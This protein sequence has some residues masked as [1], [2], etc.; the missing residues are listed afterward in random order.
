MRKRRVLGVVGVGV[1]GSKT[2]VME[3]AVSRITSS[4][5][6]VDCLEPTLIEPRL[7]LSRLMLCSLTIQARQAIP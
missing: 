2:C 7:H 1:G 5:I 4:G 6:E 3:M